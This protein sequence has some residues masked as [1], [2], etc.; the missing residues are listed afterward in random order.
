[1]GYVESRLQPGE[2]IIFK[3]N[4]GRKWYHYLLWILPYIILVPIIV[5]LL[6]YFLMPMLRSLL[7][8]NVTMLIGVGFLV[9]IGLAILNDIVHYFVDELALTD[10]RIVGRSQNS[11]SGWLF[12]K[13]NAP[14]SEIAS[15]NTFNMPARL[16]FQFRD[17]R[18][19]LIVKNLRDNKQFA[20]K[21]ME[22]KKSAG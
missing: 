22:A 13:I 20:E 19:L 4:R 17:G 12:Q 18:H 5:F 1:M 7:P 6:G 21:L 11:A 15:I 14:L 8:D 10:R 16:V 3:I 9:L 2:H